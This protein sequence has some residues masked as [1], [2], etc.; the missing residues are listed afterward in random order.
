MGLTESA[1]KIIMKPLTHCF[2]KNFD[3][4]LE[5]CCCECKCSTLENK[6]ETENEFLYIR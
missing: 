6:S 4:S 3:F 1:L 2:G 5:C